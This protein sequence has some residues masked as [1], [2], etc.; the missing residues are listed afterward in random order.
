MVALVL[1]ASMLTSCEQTDQETTVYFAS[2]KGEIKGQICNGVII[3][4][5]RMSFKV[6]VNRQEVLFWYDDNSGTV[7]K[8]N[9]C[10]VRDKNSWN[11]RYGEQMWVMDNGNFR[12]SPPET[13]D[14]WFVISKYK[15]WPA[16]IRD[17]WCG[18]TK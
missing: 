2:C 18:P 4:E 9:D 17:W 1:V 12:K 15:W 3:P 10:V 14:K 11:C 7:R 13:D 8:L 5:A 6:L 16:Y